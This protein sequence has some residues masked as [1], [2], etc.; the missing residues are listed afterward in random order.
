MIPKLR[1]ILKQYNV[2]TLKKLSEALKISIDKIK[3]ISCGRTSITSLFRERSQ[4]RILPKKSEE[5]AELIGVILGDGNIYQFPRC[6]RLTISCNSSYKIYV[7]HIGNLIK[8]V[9]KKEPSILKRSKAKCVDVRLYMQDI[10]K[11]LGLLAGNKIK[12]SVI[13]PEWI[14]KS[15]KYLIKCLKGLFETDGHYALNRKFHVEYIQFCNNSK[16]LRESVSKALIF[17]GYS[18]QLGKTYVRLARKAQVHR[19]L[20]EMDFKRP[21][22]SLLN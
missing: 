10:D 22:P 1:K 17:L 8:R 11:A 5:F 6:Q 15:K 13:I 20:R 16:S 2:S 12:N 18:P 7:K 3:N 14:L 21:F 9:F 4:Y 19:F